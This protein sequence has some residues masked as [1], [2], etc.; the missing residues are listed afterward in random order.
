MDSDAEACNA[1][2]CLPRRYRPAPT[3][4]QMASVLLRLDSDRPKGLRGGLHRFQGSHPDSVAFAAHARQS[5]LCET[6]WNV[7]LDWLLQHPIKQAAV[8]RFR[9][10]EPRWQHEGRVDRET[11]TT[12]STLVVTSH[13][14]TNVVLER[15][16]SVTD[17]GYTSA[18]THDWR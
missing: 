15:P 16:A 5:E 14:Q 18:G 8:D 6:G 17:R 3:G 2:R 4:G 13:L 12:N 1:A 7:F 9:K 11:M 10:H